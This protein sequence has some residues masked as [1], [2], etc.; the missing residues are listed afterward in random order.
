MDWSALISHYGYLAIFIGTFFEGETVLLLGAY[1]VHQHIFNF[2]ILIAIAMLGSFTGDQL[3]YQIGKKYGEP[4][5]Q[6]RPKLAVRF[7]QASQFIE[8]YP[9]LTILLM[10]FAWGLRTIIPL[11]FGIKK[12]SILRYMLV[13]ILACF[14]WAFV[15]VSV[16]LQ[17]SHWLHQLLKMLVP[18]HH[19]IMVIV[20]MLIGIAMIKA[21]LHISSSQD[22]KI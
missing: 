11:S 22:K 9:N 15:V 10:R 13:N 17:M 18:Q 20:I 7:D 2:W 16:G 6:N 3:Y 5:I 21:I 19:V 12:Y 14:I 4:F 1:A 8:R